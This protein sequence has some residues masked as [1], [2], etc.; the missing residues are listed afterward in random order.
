[1][2]SQLELSQVR[3]EIDRRIQEKEEEFENTRWVSD[4][5]LMLTER[6]DAGLFTA[7]A[8][9]LKHIFLHI[10]LSSFVFRHSADGRYA[11]IVTRA[12]YRH[13]Q[14]H[15]TKTFYSIPLINKLSNV[16]TRWQLHQWCHVI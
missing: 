9:S 4:K 2:R 8:R 10:P 12:C 14:G 5:S 6:C 7:N 15:S 1:L 16:C 3:Q 11:F 13:N